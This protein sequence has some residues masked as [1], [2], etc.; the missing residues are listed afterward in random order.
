MSNLIFTP[1]FYTKVRLDDEGHIVE[2]ENLEKEDLPL[3]QHSVNEINKTE[4]KDVDG[5][6]DLYLQ[7]KQYINALFGMMVTA[8]IQANV[9]LEDDI[10]SVEKLTEFFIDNKLSE[11]I[12]FEIHN[13]LFEIIINI[14]HII[15]C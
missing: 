14:K 15:P 4:L 9:T 3:H 2:A 11:F 8:I 13:F 5:M 12:T 6:E 10:W 7:S 1:G